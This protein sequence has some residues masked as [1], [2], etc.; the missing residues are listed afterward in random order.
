MGALCLGESPCQMWLAFITSNL[1]PHTHGFWKALP[2]LFLPEAL[3]ERSVNFHIP[4]FPLVPIFPGGNLGW[5]SCH[6]V[7]SLLSAPCRS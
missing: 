4:G 5:G 2:F 1:F 7:S 3:V 6:L